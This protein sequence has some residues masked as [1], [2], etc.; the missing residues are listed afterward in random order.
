MQDP[1]NM[2]CIAGCPNPAI[3]VCSANY[4]CK[5]RGCN[6]KMCAEHRSKKC[7]PKER[8]WGPAPN[9]CINC[10]D[11]VYKC[12]CKVMWCPL[13]VFFSICCFFI[14]INAVASSI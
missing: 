5:E 9:V 3:F 11:A 8:K 14:L 10:E 7:F 13:V 4:Y 6:R 12:G 2:C 1:A